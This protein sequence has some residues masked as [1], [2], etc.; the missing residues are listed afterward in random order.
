MKFRQ[1]LREPLL[2]FLLIGLAL[3]A[4]YGVVSPGDF[5]GQTITVSQ[6]D[7]AELR[8]QYAA[9]WGRPPTDKELAGLIDARVRDEI[10][11]REGMAQGLGENDPVIKR[12]VRQK[13]EVM[14]EEE[15]ADVAPTDAVLTAY[16]QSHRDKFAKPAVVSFD[17]IYFNPQGPDTPASVTAARARLNA[18]G[19]T[20]GIGQATMLPAQV[21]RS[22]ADLVARDFGADFAKALVKLPVGQ[23]SGPIGSGVGVHLVRLTELVPPKAPPLAEVRAEVVREWENDR[24]IKASEA[25]YARARARYNVVIEGQP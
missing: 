14:A 5:G 23:W 4:L 17:Q 3:F 9:L 10:L 11:Y 16:L 18:G 7:V 6:G 15:G 8:R 22:D 21:T 13:V 24:R 25:S 2:H 19:G 12:R 20:A 1:V